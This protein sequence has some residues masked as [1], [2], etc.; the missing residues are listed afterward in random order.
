MASA[1]PLPRS[2]EDAVRLQREVTAELERV[3][4]S[5]HFRTSRRSCEFLRYVVRVTLEGRIDSLKER[6]IGMDLIG[7]DSS[8]DP[9]SDATV[10]VR[11]NEVRK[12]LVTYYSS[13]EPGSLRIVLP[14]GTYVPRFEARTAPAMA[15]PNPA[16]ERAAVAGAD[17]IAAV[18]PLS[19]LVLMR[20][21]L[22]ALLICVLLLRHQLESRP[23]YLRFWDRILAGR[24]ALLLSVAP[25]SGTRLATSLYPLEWIAGRYDV[26][27]A[28]DEA[29]VTGAASAA[30]A[31]V[32]ISTES[33]AAWKAD[34]RLL[35][36]LSSSEP[37]VL[38]ARRPAG[39]GEAAPGE[40]SALLTIL[41]ENPSTLYAQSAD[42]DA[43][44]T[45]FDELTNDG[46]FPRGLIEPVASSKVVQMLVVRDATGHWITETWVQP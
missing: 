39:P 36:M 21:A 18:A 33:P 3:C 41:P 13:A 31:T 35:W 38:L 6:S 1:P 2:F 17:P 27:T 16:D 29:A 34:S 30:F 24:S 14:T 5:P 23:D 40:R 22:L 45:L 42:E 10:R 19:G 25:E 20:P 32:R 11:A 7:R 46:R 26:A 12:R 15:L 9:S 43:L 28:L 4:V 8:Y 44:R 37:G